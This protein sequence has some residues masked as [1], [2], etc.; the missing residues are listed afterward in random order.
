VLAVLG[1]A[2]TAGFERKMDRWAIARDGERFTAECRVIV[3]MIEQKMERYE[4]ALGRLRDTCARD[5]GEISPEIGP[6]GSII[7]WTW[8]TITPTPEFCWWLPRF[9]VLT[10]RTSDGAR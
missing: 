10:G 2:S 8:A 6:A 3:A 5:H 4:T 9:P 1:V 7:S